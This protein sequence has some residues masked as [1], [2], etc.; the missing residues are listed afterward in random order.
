MAKEPNSIVIYELKGKSL[1]AAKRLEQEIIK[2]LNVRAVQNTGYLNET[3]D[4]W[5]EFYARLVERLRLEDPALLELTGLNAPSVQ[6]FQGKDSLPRAYR[7]YPEIYLSPEKNPRYFMFAPADYKGDCFTPADGVMLN[8]KQERAVSDLLFAG[9]WI[10]N[11]PLI[12][13][14]KEGVALPAGFQPEPRE[15]LQKKSPEGTRTYRCFIA[16]GKSLAAVADFDRRTEEYR[17]ACDAV[18]DVVKKAAARSFPE[19]LK[20]L[21]A[22]EELRAD[23][24]YRYGGDRE[25]KTE[26]LLSVRM[27]GKNNI[28]NAGKTVPLVKNPFFTWTESQNGEYTIIAREDTPEGKLLSAMIKAVPLTPSLKDYRELLGN[29][30]YSQD[31]IDVAPGIHGTVPWVKK[32]NALTVLVYNAEDDDKGNFCPPDAKPLPTAAYHWLHSDDS[33]KNLGIKPPPMPPEISALLGGIT[34]AP[35]ISSKKPA[36]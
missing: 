4:S 29:F 11:A 7:S 3:R 34:K 1:E 30:S 31:Q 12:G 33:D 19:M 22:G 16:D 6:T 5:Q 17:A 35:A 36:L 23:V 10:G 20:S 24:S 18:R 25:G 27:E 28:W 13:L 9:G 21:P 2:D 8:E 26:F 32:F 14:N 15:T